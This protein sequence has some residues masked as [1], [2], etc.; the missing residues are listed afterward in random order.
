M[1]TERWRRVKD[2]VY[3]A[4][5]LP[6]E[7][8][9]VYL[10]QACNGD[11]TLRREVEALISASDRAGTFLDEPALPRAITEDL[12][13]SII[14]AYRLAAE[15][16]RGG[17]GVVYRAVR[18]DEFRQEA[19][20]K[21]VKRG[22][23]TDELLARFRHE[24]RILALLNHPN[25]ARMLDG[26]T[27]ADGRPYF[28]MELVAGQRIDT[29]CEEKGLGIE[30]RLR[31]FLKVC[32]AVAHA[33]RNLVIHRDLKPANILI[34]AEGD[35]KLL[36]FGIAKVF[37]PD[38]TGETAGLTAAHVRLLTPEYASPEQVRGDRITTASD[39]YSLG[40]IL[41]E[42][43]T[44]AKAHR[45]A[46]TSPTELE[47]VICIVE[48]P[49][50][51]E[52]STERR[53]LRGDLD[54]IILK[55]LQKQPERR[56][57]HVEQFAED[58]GRYL[59]GRPIL[60]RADTIGYRVA[61]FCRRNTALTVAA[62][63]VLV[64][65]MA[66]IIGVFWQA[67]IAHREK[68]VAERR[69]NEVRELANSFLFEVYDA[70]RDLPGSTPARKLIVDRALQY[71]DRLE[72]EASK[73]R[74]LQRELAVA[75]ERVGDVQANPRNANLGDT[76]G[77]LASYR[78]AL[79]IRQ[80]LLAV[81]PND[82]R[83]QRELSGNYTKIGVCLEA[84]GDYSSALNNMQ[85]ALVINQKSAAD[86]NS[87][88]A[89][90]RLAGNYFWIAELFSLTSNPAGALENYRKAAAIREAA[91][92]VF[93]DYVGLRTH[94]AADS[95]GIARVLRQTGDFN[96]AIQSNRK[97]LTI[98]EE[99]SAAAPANAPLREYVAESYEDLGS[100]LEGNGDLAKALESFRKAQAMFQALAVADP[101]DVLAKRLLGFT[102]QQIGCIMVDQGDPARGL[103][104]LRSGL[105]IFQALP[106]A[107]PKNIYI[108]SGFAD[109]YFGFG[110]AYSALASGKNIP[111]AKQM[112]HWREARGWYQKSLDIWLDMRSHNGL[113]PDDSEKPA[114]IAREIAKCDAALHRAAGSSAIPNWSQ[115]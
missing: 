55:A 90:D 41:Y 100:L 105:A 52:T 25:I 20:I 72:K 34:T 102:Y 31:L 64:T 108:L 29:Y 30:D 7:G 45:L 109:S 94:L 96:Q 65:L 6:A 106:A 51:S 32:G 82:R 92:A 56:Y 79:A 42:L 26:G 70:I 11:T 36:D 5:E 115:R 97:G 91:L 73:D 37:T 44:G 24:R 33:H 22:M 35:P 113:T 76:A 66:G 8:R 38:Q 62:A 48:P 68:A 21:I 87:P 23:D 18:D 3:T 9:E 83:I 1:T 47:R 89:Q 81:D 86:A 67:R 54:N 17:M 88:D 60:A 111:L 85:Q 99:L 98:L 80:S 53:A 59:D 78:K 101:T 19:A 2:I 75:Y 50:P 40:A 12:T 103:E 104:S 84:T 107:G 15:I 57:L 13:G 63:L 74:S 14:G 27:T 4:V 49:K 114:R 61:K 10:D 110:R 28:V 69:F 16:G 95:L 77:G 71:L 43:L 58:I 93:P 39:I 112:E 46:N